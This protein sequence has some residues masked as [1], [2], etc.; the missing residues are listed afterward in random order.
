MM[1]AGDKPLGMQGM[2]LRDVSGEMAGSLG[3]ESSGDSRVFSAL[4]KRA[5]SGKG[6]CAAARHGCTKLASPKPK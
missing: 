6:T 3:F 2:D 4:S 1:S 5:G